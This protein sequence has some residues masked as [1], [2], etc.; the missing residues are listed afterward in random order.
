MSSILTYAAFM[1]DSQTTLQNEA[2]ILRLMLTISQRSFW[3]FQTP[4]VPGV[5]QHCIEHTPDVL[6]AAWRDALRRSEHGVTIDLVDMATGIEATLGVDFE[7][8]YHKLLVMIDTDW[9]PIDVP[10]SADRMRA[11]ITLCE[12][13]YTTL[14][15]SYG[16]GF[17]TPNT[18]PLEQYE[19]VTSRIYAIY[20]YNFFG[21]TQVQAV[22][23]YNVLSIPAWRTHEFE[24]G[25]VLLEMMPYPV[26]TWQEY[27][28]HYK[29]AAHI[30]G[31]SRFQQ[32]W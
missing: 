30:M 5:E 3:R 1:F 16:Y 32:G 11:Y 18:V 2:N 31:I 20:D 6:A 15:P 19:D 21:P 29:Y 25:G 9:L 14:H 22:G 24:D 26:W 13:V 12:L 27:T 8:R 23:R 4:F 7:H 28:P 10:E 17:T